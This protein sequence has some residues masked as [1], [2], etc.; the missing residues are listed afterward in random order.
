MFDTNYFAEIQATLRQVRMGWDMWSLDGT[1][2]SRL[3]AVF[4]A[5]W[6]SYTTGQDRTL[7]RDGGCTSGSLVFGSEDE[8][9]CKVPRAIQRVENHICFRDSDYETLMRVHTTVHCR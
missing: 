3:A 7:V 6:S 1:G 9:D 8:S 4:V 5:R 2:S